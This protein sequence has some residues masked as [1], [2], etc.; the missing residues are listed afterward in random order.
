[1]TDPI[2]D[3]LTRIRNASRVRKAE[4]FVPFSKLK[5][6]I[7]KILKK[8]GFIADYQELKPDAANKFG[9]IEIT[10]KYDNGNSAISS[11]KRISKPGR[12]IYAS[13]DEIPAVR[14]NFGISIISTSGGVMT[15]KEARK[16]GL[17]GEILCEIY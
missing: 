15:N 13:T 17:G 8:E 7:V 2:A 9:G 6:G 14:N 12:R 16:A 11:L 4:V 5:L 10:L 1:M 3:L